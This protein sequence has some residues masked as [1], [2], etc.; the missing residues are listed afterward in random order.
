MS[1]SL[2][3]HSCDRRVGVGTGAWPETVSEPKRDRPWWASRCE[4]LS[5]SRT[6]RC[7]RENEAKAP[8]QMGGTGRWRGWWPLRRVFVG[9]GETAGADEELETH[10]TV[11]AWR[12]CHRLKAKDGGGFR[13]W[14][15]IDGL[16]LRRRRGV[17]CRVFRFIN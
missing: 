1:R 9:T 4:D 6:L 12:V 3:R 16:R 7:A 10:T 14:E 2:S 11:S 5:L 8:R 17:V 13:L 15:R